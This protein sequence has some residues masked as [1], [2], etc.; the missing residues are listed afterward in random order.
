MQ[1]RSYLFRL[2]LSSHESSDFMP[3]CLS[4]SM[5]PAGWDSLEKQR[6]GPSNW[7]QKRAFSSWTPSWCAYTSSSA[8]AQPLGSARMD[9]RI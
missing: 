8:I 1:M 4:S 5:F 7:L 6:L 9:V 2:Q 3:N